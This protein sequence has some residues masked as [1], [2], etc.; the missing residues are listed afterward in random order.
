MQRRGFEWAFRVMTEPRRLWRRY[1]FNIPPFVWL[2]AL[3][4]LGLRRFPL[5]DAEG[6][7][8]GNRRR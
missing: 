7:L 5:L 1:A 6:G 3:Q 4:W 8:P 2:T